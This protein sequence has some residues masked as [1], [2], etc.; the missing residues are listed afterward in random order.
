MKA[1]GSG[2]GGT[3]SRPRRL[4]VDQLRRFDVIRAVTN[5]PTENTYG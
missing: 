4:K 3:K 1:K 2:K 5:A